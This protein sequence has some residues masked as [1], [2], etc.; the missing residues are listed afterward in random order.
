M[1]R[2]FERGKTIFVRLI[3]I[4]GNCHKCAIVTVFIRA[5]ERLVYHGQ[6]TFAVLASAFRDELLNPQT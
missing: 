2:R 6:G 5:S 1:T 4:R 3:A